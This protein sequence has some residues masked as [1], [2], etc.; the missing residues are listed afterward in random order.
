YEAFP[1]QDNGWS[2]SKNCNFAGDHY[3]YDALGRQTQLWHSDD[4]STKDT[5][6]WGRAVS[7]LEESN[8]ST[9]VQRI[10]Q[11]DA[12][13]RLRSVCEVSSAALPGGGGS[14]VDCGLDIGG[15][16]FSTSYDYDALGNLT[17]VHQAGLADR[18]FSYDSLSELV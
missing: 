13:G 14:P 16:G 8:G 18:T 11:S 12:L 1:F 6:Y 7:A 2:Y 5:S 3:A 15:T 9:R 4:G 17:A 10:Q